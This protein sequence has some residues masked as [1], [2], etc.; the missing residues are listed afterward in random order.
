MLAPGQNIAAAVESWLSQF[1]AALGDETRLKALFHGESHWRDVLA[2][3]WRIQTVNGAGNI[4]PALKA[5]AG[6]AKPRDIRIDPDRTPPR[7]VTRTR[8][9]TIEAI[10]RFETA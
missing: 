2:L 6:Q 8:V 7:L 9:E 4:V 3:T 1:E 10:F 5:S